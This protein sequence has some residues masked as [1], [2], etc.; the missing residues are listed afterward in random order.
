[1]EKTDPT[2][3]S[4]QKNGRI[5]FYLGVR[6]SRSV[7]DPQFEFI[8][9]KWDEFMSL[10]KFP[11]AVVECKF[12]KIPETEKEVILKTGEAGFVEFLAKNNKVPVICFEPK[13]NEEMNYLLN[14][15]TK[16][17]IEYY[18]FARTIAQWHR[19]IEKPSIKE[20]LIPYLERDK[21]ASGW[22]DFEFSI[23]NMKRIHKKLFGTDLN[24]NNVEHFR[25]IEN[26]TKKDNPFK[27]IVRASGDFRDKTIIEKIKEAWKTK[28]I[29]V[30]YGRG[31][32]E[33]HRKEL[34][35][36]INK[37]TADKL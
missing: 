21:N 6:H 20:Y 32:A 25:K 9:Q 33:A 35:K 27:E 13:R 10:A 2:F 31:H 22:T 17:Q 24:F 36:Y 29:F 3:F 37:K 30:V 12:E 34:E 4:L 5:L 23:E 26:P 8:R 15:F 11:L 18:Y 19:L 1:M 7:G 16:E 28:D 14:Y